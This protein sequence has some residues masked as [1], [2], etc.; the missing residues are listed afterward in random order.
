MIRLIYQM[1]PNVHV[2]VK[3]FLC[4]FCLLVRG[5]KKG[6]PFLVGGPN[7]QNDPYSP[8]ASLHHLLV[9]SA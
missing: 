3:H 1:P 7:D 5:L 4:S 9:H 8:A 6:W 2:S